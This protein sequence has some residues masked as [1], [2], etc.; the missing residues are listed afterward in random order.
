MG[1]LSIKEASL[2]FYNPIHYSKPKA[3][4]E[5][6]FEHLKNGLCLLHFSKCQVPNIKNSCY[7][8]PTAVRRWNCPRGDIS[9]YFPC[10]ICGGV[11]SVTQQALWVTFPLQ[12]P[13][14]ERC[15][16]CALSP[17]RPEKPA[18][19]EDPSIRSLARPKPFQL[20]PEVIHLKGLN[21]QWCD[22][23]KFERRW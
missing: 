20:Q 21:T 9:L 22:S 17:K 7:I 11:C 19:L 15:R 3:F 23:V 18:N 13:L 14:M 10:K 1:S 16:H 12:A 8:N 5:S 2:C 6:T 4:N